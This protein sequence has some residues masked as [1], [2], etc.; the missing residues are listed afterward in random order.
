MLSLFR[1]PAPKLLF[2]VAAFGLATT[3]E[4]QTVPAGN[5]D[6]GKIL[7]QQNCALCHWSGL[8]GQP[9]AAQGP[10]L[11]GIIGRPAA[12]VPNFSYTKALQAS[13]LVWD[14]ATLNRFLA[15]PGVVVPGTSMPI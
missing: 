4:A 13:H 6:H 7:Y 3:A 11:A 10:L 15:A 12:S 8:K 1:S 2:L 14:T 9:M 5:A